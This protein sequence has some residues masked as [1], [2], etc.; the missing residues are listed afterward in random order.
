MGEA[1]AATL[2]ALGTVLVVASA[3]GVNRFDDVFCRMHAAT[4]AATLGVILLSLAAMLRVDGAAIPKLALVIVL[5]LLTAPLG[6]H[7]LGR[8]A[9]Q[10]GELSPRTVLDE[11]ADPAG[12][13]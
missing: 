12:D 1:V 10:R 9:H 6:A 4:K 13:P 3:L 7:L 8:A 11:L 2:V 5:Q